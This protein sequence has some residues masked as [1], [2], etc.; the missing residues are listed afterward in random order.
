[1]ALPADM[2]AAVYRAP[3]TLSV[4][5]VPVPA[6]EPGQLLIEI[7]HCGVC[8]SDL[9]LVM[10]G[11]GVPGTIFGHEYSGSVVAVGE[12]VT[13]W[14]VGDVLVG[15]PGPGC[16]ACRCCRKGRPNLC[17]KHALDSG[18]PGAFAL[19][20]PVDA[21][22]AFAVPA[23]LSS[24]AA[25]LTEPLAVALHGIRRGSVTA[26]DRVLITGGGPIGLLTAVL[27]LAQG[28]EDVT[29]S[30]PTPSRRELAAALGARAVEPGQLGRPALAPELVEAPYQV[31]IE[32]SGRPDAMEVALAN[33]DRA[34][35]LV[36]SGT[37]MRRPKLDSNRIILHELTVTGTIEYVPDDYHESL[38]LLAAGRIPLELLV[39]PRDRA[40]GELQ[41]AMGELVHGTL[42][43]K[44][45]VAPGA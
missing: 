38:A 39:E 26:E 37:G 17:D 6:P 29:V 11:W 18:L 14:S 23:G 33:L 3:G 42:A 40:L 30:E 44:V 13:G 24:R 31:A 35:T 28:V 21:S 45:M 16:G 1:M 9:H 41:S 2:P 22:A 36:F 19:Y 8:G 27:L 15:G 12:G 4:E 7:S 34:G 10:E 32:C 25:A 20:K 43:G 5:R